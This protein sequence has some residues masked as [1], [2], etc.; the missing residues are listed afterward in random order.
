MRAVVQRVSK[1]A[2]LVDGEVVGRIGQGLVVFAAVGADDDEAALTW[3][4]EKVVNL[5]IFSDDAGR[6]EHSLRDVGGAVLA[7]SQFT[8]YGDCR[9][10]RRPSFTAAA[11]PDQARSMF[12]RFVVA[13]RATGVPVETGVFQASMQVEVSN[14]GPVTILLDS[15]RTF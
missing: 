15:A 14:E 3:T 11:A 4:A 2:V 5:R 12:E 10:G 7:V 6:F 13:L 9:K 8:L 1:A